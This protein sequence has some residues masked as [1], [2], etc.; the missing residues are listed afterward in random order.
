MG[1]DLR[2]TVP[3]RLSVPLYVNNERTKFQHGVLSESEISSQFLAL[4]PRTKSGSTNN[5]K[6]DFAYEAVSKHCFVKVLLCME[7][8]FDV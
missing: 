6:R 7:Y 1:S 5:S 3:R 4:T 2:R 8:V